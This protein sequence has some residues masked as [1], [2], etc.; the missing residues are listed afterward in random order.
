L[1]YD[2][3]GI[4][5]NMKAMTFMAY[6]T[7]TLEIATVAMNFIG[8]KRGN[9]LISGYRPNAGRLIEAVGT[10]SDQEVFIDLKSL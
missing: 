10:F 8:V 4:V 7:P 1:E 2:K 3:P 5:G 9:F 6:G